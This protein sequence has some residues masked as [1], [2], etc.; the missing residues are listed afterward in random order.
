MLRPSG[1]DGFVAHLSRPAPVAR[2]RKPPAVH[3]AVGV[4]EAGVS[5]ASQ[6]HAVQDFSVGQ[7][8]RYK[9]LSF[10]SDQRL[11]NGGFVGRLQPGEDRLPGRRRL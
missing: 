5:L 1:D 4:S 6:S 11:G 2:T 3:V 9:C 8:E 10:R 7:L